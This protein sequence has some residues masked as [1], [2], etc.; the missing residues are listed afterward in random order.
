VSRRLGA[1]A[2]LEATGWPLLA[3]RLA[4]GATLILYSFAKLVQPFDFLKELNNYRVLPAQP[5]QVL[6]LTALLMPWAEL[7]LGTALLLGLLVRGAAGLVV[8]MLTV[9]T[10]AIVH[11]AIG[12]Q[13]AESVAFCA[14]QF[15]CGCGTGVVNICKKLVQN[16]ALVALGLVVL[17]S[18]SRRFCLSRWISGGQDRR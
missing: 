13:Q 2:R 7:V 11:R 15:D 9:F 16:A 3:A 10:A 1:L 14:V 12:V 4:V 18:N 6:N 5:P 17:F 8:L